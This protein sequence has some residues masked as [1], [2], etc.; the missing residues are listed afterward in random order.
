[1]HITELGDLAPTAALLRLR[2]AGTV[3]LDS[4]MAHPQL[5]RWSFL[6]V[7]PFAL[8]AVE[9]GTARL[10]GQPLGGTP[11]EALRR[12]VERY[13]ASRPE[14]DDLPPFTGG[15]AGFLSYEFGRH[16]DRVPVAARPQPG[17]PDAAF[18]LYDLVL[19]FDGVR[20]RAMLLSSGLPEAG[21][22][23]RAARATARARWVLDRLAR[24]APPPGEAPPLAFRSAVGRAEHEAAVARVVDYVLAGDI[25]QANLARRISAPLP[26]GYDTLAAY[27]RLRA[28]NPAPFA[29][30]LDLAGI[31]VASA[32]PERFLKH[33]GGRVEARPIKGTARRSADPEED[34][35]LAGALVA[36]DKDRA[37][38]VMIVDL[39]RSD[40]SRVCRPHGVDVPVL[41][42]LETY[43][44]VHH[45]VS[46]VTGELE[47][48]RDVADLLAAAFPG[49]SITGAPK[50][51][52][53]EIIAALEGVARGVYC[54]SIGWIGF[55][56]DADLN[57][58]IRTVTFAGGE[59]VLWSGGGIT[60]L[61]DPAAEYE[62][63]EA[64]AAA[65]LDAL[66]GGA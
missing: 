13:A 16:L 1:M 12:V 65:I 36:S 20:G 24:P 34:A 43:A 11:V 57:I 27:L 14:G 18:G 45:L 47:P 15:L 28:R 25:F 31:Q 64:K 30:W 41:A 62:E 38:N 6:A 52:A 23:A 44:S 29:A 32:S 21:E 9:D 19:A 55:D 66:G 26:P 54:G 39:L 49:G 10:D 51:R 48:G 5:G 22:P 61:S 4:A 53:M 58:A 56:G 42:G 17:V 37:E 35:R 2:G 59:A 63:T 60:A 3:F 7:D 8:F 40:L 46:V 33:S 50:I